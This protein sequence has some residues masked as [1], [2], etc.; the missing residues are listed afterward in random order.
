ML[1]LIILSIDLNQI[2]KNKEFI[3][4]YISSFDNPNLA[5]QKV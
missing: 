3:F 2:I 4:G 1:K 5:I